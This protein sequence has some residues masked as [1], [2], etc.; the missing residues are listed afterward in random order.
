MID[1]QV[2]GERGSVIV[3]GVRGLDWKN[4]QKIEQ[5]KFPYLGSL[6]PYADTMF[7]ARQVVRMRE[8]L[9]D[10]RIVEILGAEVVAEIEV[11]C[12]RVESESHLYLWFL[13]D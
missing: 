6:L 8:E 4:V 10:V 7:N 1:V 2:R 9:G 3:R 11:L 13:G 12:R 5:S